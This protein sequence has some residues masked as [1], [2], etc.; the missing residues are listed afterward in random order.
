[1]LILLCMEKNQPKQSICRSTL[2][3]DISG[4]QDVQ[5][6]ITVNSFKWWI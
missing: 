6:F 1:M 4:K 5:K 3:A 2:Y